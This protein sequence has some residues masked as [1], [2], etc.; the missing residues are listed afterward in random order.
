[1]ALI[2][3]PSCS[4]KISDKAKQCAHCH[5]DFTNVVPEDAERKRSMSKFKRSQKIQNQSML[6]MLMFIAGFAVMFMGGESVDTESIK[7]KA[8]MS[9][10]VI[11]FIWY[12]V[13]RVRMIWL[14]R[15]S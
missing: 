8:A 2:D 9:C 13:N 5:T 12:I 6:A 10:T 1:M 7:Y 3:C 15:S 4:K 11:G 14:K